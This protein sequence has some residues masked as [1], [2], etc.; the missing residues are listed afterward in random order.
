[1]KLVSTHGKT[2]EPVS[3]VTAQGRQRSFSRIALKQHFI[4]TPLASEC[5]DD[6]LLD[7][8]RGQVG[9]DS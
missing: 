1:M 9:G 2:F 6:I 8:P 7:A 4:L 5:L 3:H